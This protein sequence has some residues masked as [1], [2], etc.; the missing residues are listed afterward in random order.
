MWLLLCAP[1]NALD[2]LVHLW[3]FHQAGWSFCQ[4]G[5]SHGRTWTTSQTNDTHNLLTCLELSEIFPTSGTYKNIHFLSINECW[6]LIRISGIQVMLAGKHLVH[7]TY[8][9]LEKVL[10]DLGSGFWL[11]IS[12]HEYH[13]AKESLGNG[14]IGQRNRNCSLWAVIFLLGWFFFHL[15]NIVSVLCIYMKIGSHT[16]WIVQ[17][18]NMKTEIV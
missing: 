9:Y 12:V 2:L 3:H 13:W 7:I 17:I 11:G 18:P 1:L 6:P 4:T 5:G 8:R 10:H 15:V 14:I 16:K